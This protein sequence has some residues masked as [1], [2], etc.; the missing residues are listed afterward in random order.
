MW[1]LQCAVE[2]V[3]V[4]DMCLLV[5]SDCSVCEGNRA[6]VQRLMCVC[7]HWCQQYQRLG[8]MIQR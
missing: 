3:A 4:S 2:C 1:L 6:E 7:V 8:N 5:Y